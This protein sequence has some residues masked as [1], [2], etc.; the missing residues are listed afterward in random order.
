[1][2]RVTATERKRKRAPHHT[3]CLECHRA[4]RSCDGGRPCKRCV[5]Q[6]KEAECKTPP[7]KER[8]RKRRTKNLWANEQTLSLSI[9]H[10]ASTSTG[11]PSTLVPTTAGAIVKKPDEQHQ[12]VLTALLQQIRQLNDMTNSLKK[13]QQLLSQ[14]LLTFKSSQSKSP[15]VHDSLSDGSDYSEDSFS[16][17]ASSPPSGSFSEGPDDIEDQH[18]WNSFDSVSSD[19]GYMVEYGAHQSDPVSNTQQDMLDLI[20]VTHEPKLPLTPVPVSKDLQR[21]KESLFTPFA[22]QDANKVLL[23][24]IPKLLSSNCNLFN[25]PFFVFKPIVYN[26]DLFILNNAKETPHC[27]PGNKVAACI[28][29][30]VNMPFC[31]LSQYP[32]VPSTPPPFFL[33]FA[34]S[35][36]NL[37]IS[38]NYRKSL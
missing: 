8:V 4:H 11:Y 36:L 26:W 6:G 22:I 28:I 20:D 27:D 3:A 13:N 12:P 34:S 21:F 23:P 25:Q 17:P 30:T 7:K 29:L 31:A 18:A 1:M 16:T 33:F 19:L 32:A 15:T 9:F 38:M 24:V 2:Q 35:F 14:Q 10:Q 37:T 5:A